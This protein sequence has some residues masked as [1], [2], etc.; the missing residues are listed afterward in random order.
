MLPPEAGSTL[1]AIARAAIGER[2][3]AAPAPHSDAAWLHRPG[4]AFVTLT[5][6]RRL[7]GCV[8]TIEAYRPLFRDVAGNAVAAAFGDARFRQL[9][10]DEFDALRIEV[11][12]LSVLEP[13]AFRD[14]ADALAQLRPGIDGVV[15]GCGRRRSTFLPQVW[16]RLP[17][18][19]SF[20]ASLKVKAGLHAV[21][22]DDTITL[23]RYT[24][25]SWREPEAPGTTVKT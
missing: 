25:T 14:E 7:R 8:G 4:A 12:L 15:L 10:Q 23:A 3:G 19:A 20:L 24:V 5:V 18:P 11:S 1:W 21:Y 16:E 2:W 6:D 17:D 22:W 13:L 9:R